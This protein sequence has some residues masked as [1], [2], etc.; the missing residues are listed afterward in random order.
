[1]KISCGFVYAGV[2]DALFFTLTDSGN[3]V[4]QTFTQ[5]VTAGRQYITLMFNFIPTNYS[6]NFTITATVQQGGLIS[7]DTDDYYCVEVYQFQP[8]A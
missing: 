6:V 1:M 8:D 5:N 2:D 4:T 3:S 7:T